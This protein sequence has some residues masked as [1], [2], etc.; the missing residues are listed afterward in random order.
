MLNFGL[1]NARPFD[2]FEKS[3]QHRRAPPTI[4]LEKMFESIMAKIQGPPQ[5]FLEKISPLW[6]VSS[7][8]LSFVLIP[9]FSSNTSMVVLIQFSCCK[10]HDCS[11][12]SSDEQ[13][14][15]V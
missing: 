15:V 7:S 5:Y 13:F 4:R 2:V 14:K 6:F 10:V 9:L 12:K 1:N 8:R 3:L 11:N